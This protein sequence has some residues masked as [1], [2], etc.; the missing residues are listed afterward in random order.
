[1]TSTPESQTNPISQCSE[2]SVQSFKAQ[3]DS[4]LLA[5]LVDIS[6]PNPKA[7]EVQLLKDFGEDNEGAA[8][9]SNLEKAHKAYLVT[10]LDNSIRAKSDDVMFLEKAL[11]AQRLFDEIPPAVKTQALDILAKSKLPVFT[12]SETGELSLSGWKENSITADLGQTILSDIPVYCFRVVSI[13]EARD[14]AAT[15]KVKAKKQLHQ[16]ADAEMAD[17]T[18]PG[19]SI[20][21][22]IDK[23]V[24][25]RLKKSAPKGAAKKN[26]KD[27]KKGKNKK[28]T[29]TPSSKKVL[30]PPAPYLPKAGQKPPQA[31]KMNPKSKGKG[32]GKGKN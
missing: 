10:L 20:Q 19:P 16:A 12:Q 3:R 1:M 25:A 17:A 21:S 28:T 29:S 2:K 15:A 27:G 11:D 5:S 30:V 6:P 26:S 7:P 32:K 31:T 23:A 18:K 13:V 24:S 4:G 9:R 8:H 14:H 22:M